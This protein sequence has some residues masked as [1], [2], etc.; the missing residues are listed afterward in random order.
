MLVLRD[1]HLRFGKPSPDDSVVWINPYQPQSESDSA[2]I[3]AA[4]LIVAQIY[5]AST[6]EALAALPTK[7]T[8][9]FVPVVAAG[10][11]WPFAGRGHIRGQPDAL[12]FSHEWADTYLDNLIVQNVPFEEALQRCLALDVNATVDLD[13]RLEIG[14][15]Q[16]RQRDA[17]TDY[18]F[19]D[20]IADRFRDTHIFLTPN[21]LN[22]WFARHWALEIWRRLSFGRDAIEALDKGLV[23]TP[24]NPAALPIHP[25]VIQH[26]GIGFAN[27]T[28]RYRF[29]DIGNITFAEYAAVYLR[30]R[31]NEEL[32]AGRAFWHAGDLPQA[33]A[34]LRSGV[35]L[36]PASILGIRILTD[37]LLKL[38]CADE[39][40][41]ITRRAIALD[42][43]EPY[44]HT[45]LAKLL[46]RAG[47]RELAEAAAGQAVALAPQNAAFHSHLCQIRVANDRLV[48]AEA[49]AREAVRLEPGMADG[50][51]KLGAVLA[52]QGK[53]EEAAAAWR[54]AVALA[55]SEST[56]HVRLSEVLEQAGRVQEAE[57][58]LRCAIE[59]LPQAIDLQINLGR[60]LDRQGRFDE[61]LETARNVVAKDPG[62][63]HAQLD[64]SH[65]LTRAKQPDA[66]EAVLRAAVVAA[67]NAYMLY[68]RLAGLLERRGCL[69]GAIKAAQQ[70]ADRDPQN[71]RLRSY[72][73]RLLERNGVLNAGMQ[74][75][76]RDLEL[77]PGQGER[78]A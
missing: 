5:N 2:A 44:L 35:D 20:T 37:C 46:Q 13:R 52:R 21:H 61:A 4:D 65:Q 17:L 48:E 7:A 76:S 57:A 27:E 45:E 47:A 39:A 18:N 69:D 49:A 26:F 31:W 58:V 15:G 42:P 59:T 40:L 60:L 67:P 63:W 10:F 32:H 23:S 56:N 29:H 14:I 33:A 28:T 64:L 41:A 9:H 24:F 36:A 8:R 77:V 30:F 74:A 78:Q 72:V 68:E 19:A 6:V 73:N 43:S 16:Q 3:A 25:S 53:L 70:A 54:D 12:I 62:A 34:K 71:T 55:P 22:V 11:I 1:L 75:A 66:A 50:N 38:D 51:A